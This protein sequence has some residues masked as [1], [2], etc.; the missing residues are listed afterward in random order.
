MKENIIFFDGECNLC[1]NTIRYIIKNDKLKIFN[2]SSLQSDF[3][4]NFLIFNKIKDS[5]ETIILFYK[6]SF[7]TE[8]DAMLIIL[9]NLKGLNRLF[10][11]ILKL[12][13]RFFINFIYK[14]ISKNRYI[15]F[16]KK[17]Y[18]NHNEYAQFSERFFQ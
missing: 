13:P 8:S 16:G 18:C 1:D 5:G 17:N 3:A 4:K 10:Y 2:F 7:F 6:N 11:L 15:I 14:I 12:C 9:K